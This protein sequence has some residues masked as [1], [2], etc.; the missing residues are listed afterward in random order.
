MSTQK[1][2]LE[3]KTI[4]D[5]I[6]LIESPPSAP[7]YTLGR[8]LSAAGQHVAA[9]KLLDPATP[10]RQWHHKIR[11]ARAL[12]KVPAITLM[13]GG[14]AP[15]KPAIRVRYS[16]QLRHLAAQ[17]GITVHR[18]GRNSFTLAKPTP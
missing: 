11:L 1:H 17:N 5:L 9:L 2:P 18:M 3:G 12:L 14:G 7:G 6:A 13:I 10:A 8:T 4:R 15:S 16:K